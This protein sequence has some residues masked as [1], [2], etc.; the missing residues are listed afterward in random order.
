[1]QTQALLFAYFTANGE[2]SLE[3]EYGFATNLINWQ[4]RTADL[5]MLAEKRQ[6]RIGD[7]SKDKLEVLKRLVSS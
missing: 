1:M 5:K 6:S 2:D 7:I 4:N 3:D